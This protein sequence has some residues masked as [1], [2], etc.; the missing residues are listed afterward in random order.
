MSQESGNKKIKSVTLFED[1]SVQVIADEYHKSTD[2]VKQYTNAKFITLTV[3]TFGL[4]G[5]YKVYS[6]DDFGYF[7]NVGASENN[8]T[9]YI[10][11]DE[12]VVAR[13]GWRN[14]STETTQ[15]EKITGN[16]RTEPIQT[17]PV[18]VS[19]TNVGDVIFEV[20]VAK[21]TGATTGQLGETEKETTVQ[22][23]R[24][25]EIQLEAVK[26][27]EEVADKIRQLQRQ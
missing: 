12:R 23:V 11:T 24:R 6:N 4:Y 5:L 7:I 22:N 26:N 14:K 18:S 1:E 25:E 3:C 8:N 9:E 16:V 13:S 15:F 20:Q 17:A 27:P 19:V 21:D 10:I 2:V